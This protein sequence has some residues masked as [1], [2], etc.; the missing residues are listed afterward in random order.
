MRPGI[1]GFED[2]NERKRVRVG[3]EKVQTALS[4]ECVVKGLDWHVTACVVTVAGKLLCFYWEMALSCYYRA[5]LHGL[6]AMPTHITQT[7][8]DGAHLTHPCAS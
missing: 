4:E 2:T 5:G 8:T 3:R 7:N 6:G 1:G